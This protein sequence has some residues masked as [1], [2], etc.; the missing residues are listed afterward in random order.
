MF[1]RRPAAIASLAAISLALTGC[2]SL[3]AGA[4]PPASLLTLSPT[5]VEAPEREGQESVAIAVLTPETPA[6]LDIVRVPVN[7]SDTEVAYLQEAVWVE[8]PARL[9]RRLVGE[10]LRQRVS[11][12][13]IVLDTDDTPLLASLYVRGTLMELSY[14]APSSSVVVRY[15][16]IITSEEGG[17][18]TRRFEAREENIPAEVEFVG[19]ALNRVANEV[20]GD[21][22]DWV[23]TGG[24]ASE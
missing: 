14:D 7:V 15:Q 3:G 6:K 24:S 20:A 12:E 9:F 8:K 17:A 16:A 18:F 21:V 1:N 22:A 19:P 2:V 23:V 10:N 4:E 5:S 11:A 13:S